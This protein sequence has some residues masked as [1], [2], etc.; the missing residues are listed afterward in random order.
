MKHSIFLASLVLLLNSCIFAQDDRNFSPGLSEMT[1]DINN[2][3]YKG[4]NSVL[5]SKNGRLTYEHYFN[6]FNRDSLHD[7]R[8]S[9]KSITSL[10][11]GIAIDK[12]FIK[13]VNQK[14]FEFFPEV[15]SFAS[16]SLK[17]MIT[18]KNLLE[19]KAGF[20]CEE[21]NDTKDCEDAMSLSNDWVKFSLDLP[22][23]N[24]PGAT[25]SYTS[26][27]P[28]ILSGVIRKAAKMSVMDF[29]RIYLFEPLG[30]TKYRWTTDPS[31]NGMTAGSFYFLPGD[32]MKIGE[33]VRDGGSWKGRQVVSKKW[34]TQSTLCDIEIPDFSFMKSSRSKAALPQQTFY[35]FYWY[36]ES[37]KTSNFQYNMLFASG[38]GGQYIF[39]IPELNLTVVFTQSN[40]GSYRA[41]QA[42]EILAKYIIP[43]FRDS[44]R[45][46]PYE[47]K[48]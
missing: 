42:F 22:M 41:K 6:G 5:V 39:I 35:G 9:F 40:Y 37:L 12:G 19:M 20:D 15:P 8:S 29:A 27:D 46:P 14:V 24:K 23:K 17:R 44:T 34:V 16:D 47:Q 21:F 10:L 38:N 45:K 33:L 31:G 3:K 28:V 18:V 43:E 25:W 11:I 36:R 2:A 7:S 13:D 48:R 4:I 30:I 32:M 26:V 1:G